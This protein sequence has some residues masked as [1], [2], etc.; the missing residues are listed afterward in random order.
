MSIQVTVMSRRDAERYSYGPHDTE[1]ALISIST[2]EERYDTSV[3][4]SAYNGIKRVLRLAFDDVDGGGWAMTAEDARQIAQFVAENKDRLIIVHCDA[5]VSRSA[6]IAA[7]LLKFYNGDDTQ[8]FDNP[9]YCPNM[10]CYRLMLNQ[11]IEDQQNRTQ[12]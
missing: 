9:K 11:L 6:G 2:P 1:A 4:A 5:G 7:A 10:L 12:E 8:I 3:Y